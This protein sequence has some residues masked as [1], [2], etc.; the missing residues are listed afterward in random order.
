MYAEY[1]PATPAD[2]PEMWEI[3][4][5]AKAFMRRQSLPQ[6]QKGDPTHEGLRADIE[7][8]DARVLRQNGR[9]LGTMAL[10]FAPE[11]SYAEIDGAWGLSVPYAALH[12]VAMHPDARGTGLASVFLQAAEEEAL[13]RS[14]GY[15]RIDTHEKNKPMQGLLAKNGYVRRGGLVLKNGTEKG[16]ARLAYDKILACSVW[17]HKNENSNS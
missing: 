7:A 2:L 4:Q 5:Q 12:R 13:Q 6:W 14:Y 1:T 15:I 11:E 3:I 16:D 8:G 9:V 17:P 10:V